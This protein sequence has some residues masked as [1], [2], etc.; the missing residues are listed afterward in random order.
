MFRALAYEIVF[1]PRF[2]ISSCTARYGRYIPVCQFTGMLTARY[3]MVPPKIDRR[4]S[5]EGD[6]RLEKNG[7]RRRRRRGEEI[8]PLPP[9]PPA[10]RPRTIARPRGEKDRGD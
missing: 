1:I 6:Q 2:E 5:I 3:R 4:R 10:G 7:R 9:P 8:E